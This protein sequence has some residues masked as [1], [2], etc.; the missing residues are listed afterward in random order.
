[1]KYPDFRFQMTNLTTYLNSAR[2]ASAWIQLGGVNIDDCSRIMN[3]LIDLTCFVYW[4]VH[5]FIILY[6]NAKSIYV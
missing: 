5:Y 2:C 6:K 1:M 4:F 3:F